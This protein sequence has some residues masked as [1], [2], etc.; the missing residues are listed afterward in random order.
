MTWRESVLRER[1]NFAAPVHFWR[2]HQHSKVVIISFFSD[3]RYGRK[4]QMVKITLLIACSNFQ[5]G[6]LYQKVRFPQVASTAKDLDGE[7]HAFVACFDKICQVET[8][9]LSDRLPPYYTERRETLMKTIGMAISEQKAKT[10]TSN[11]YH[12][13]ILPKFPRSNAS[14]NPSGSLFFI[15]EQH[16]IHSKRLV[17]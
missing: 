11:A 10:E 16:I 14:G 4:L 2:L 13:H 6:T 7:N 17:I 12:C 8:H 3:R 9:I 1:K 5:H 15:S